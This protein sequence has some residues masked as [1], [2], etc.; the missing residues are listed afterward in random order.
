[1]AMEFVPGETLNDRI[2]HDGRLAWLDALK[3]LAPVL[4]GVGH[5]H[6]LGILHRDLKPA[7][8]MLATDGRVKVMDFGIACV[9]NTARLT[10]EARLVG[11]LEYLAPERALGKPPDA[12]SDIYSLGMVLYEML[13]GRLPFVG[14]TDFDLIRA[15]L[16]QKPPRPREIG[17]ALPPPIEDLL[18]TALEKDPARRF[19]D[20]GTF[21]AESSKAALAAE[22][23][24]PAAGASRRWLIAATVALAMLVIG[25]SGFGI[26][27]VVAAR[28]RRPV[29]AATSAVALPQPTPLQVL[30]PTVTL[31]SIGRPAAALPEST[32]APAPAQP[33][34][35]DVTAALAAGGGAAPLAY[36]PIYK[37]PRLG[38]AQGAPVVRQAVER[39]GV[40]F[41]LTKDQSRQLRAA[42][43]PDTL[44]QA[45]RDGYRENSR[46]AR[47]AVAAPPLPEP[48][49]SLKPPEP[50]PPAVARPTPTPAPHRRIATLASVDTLFIHP[51]PDGFDADLR[52]AIAKE[53][54]P[55]LRL[56][57]KAGDADAVLEIS[58]DGDKGGAVLGG[59]Q[60][61]L[62]LRGGQKAYVRMVEPVSGRVL[63]SAEA[64]DRSVF[65]GRGDG[66]RRIASRLA[67]R[68]KHDLHV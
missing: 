32:S 3:I 51:M 50:A 48:V 68:L 18:M 15:Q 14:D 16:N 19:Q 61:W 27:K 40:D 53:V 44:L 56:V 55:R 11:T 25:L 54:G 10:R 5:A 33:N 67:K 63:W 35:A 4:E 23:G 57:S 36:A 49:A 47:A 13:T 34:M 24:G 45:I 42:G 30:G 17:I 26:W 58:L 29:P 62:G 59:T 52:E 37:A 28:M 39:R 22:L 41:R 9:A 43:A 38:G 12:R 1:M 65:A 46:T 64:G 20:A 66:S 2:G 8:I 7:N 60:R 31:S 21:L 6:S